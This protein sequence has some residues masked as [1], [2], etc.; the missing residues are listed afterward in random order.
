MSLSSILEALTKVTDSDP[1]ASRATFVEISFGLCVAWAALD[2][3]RNLCKSKCHDQFREIVASIQASEI[4][5][6]EGEETKRLAHVKAKLGKLVTNHHLRQ[7]KVVVCFKFASIISA[8]CALFVLYF[9][10]L[11][12]C[13]KWLGLLA[14]P[15]PVYYITCY[16]LF[17]SAK[18]HL[19][20]KLK[21]YKS[22]VD[23]YERGDDSGF[24]NR[25]DETNP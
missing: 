20:W 23:D 21:K 11:T 1:L 7:D 13:G 19:S 4:A 22:F 10:L 2:D 9:S 17:W 16:I 14:V 15:V 3:F 12:Y 8:I 5:T 18:W 25:I 6:T 24:Q